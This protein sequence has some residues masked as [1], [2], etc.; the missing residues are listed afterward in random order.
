M[1]IVQQTKL[2]LCFLITLFSLNMGQA[3]SKV[4]T[5]GEVIS[6]VNKSINES[7]SIIQESNLPDLTTVEIV[8]ETTHK[9]LNDGSI[10]ILVF[11]FGKKRE[12]KATKKMTFVF[13][14]K[15]EIEQSD[16][17]D[18][19]SKALSDAI[20]QAA[21]ALKNINDDG[22]ILKPKSTT[23]ELGFYITDSKSGGLSWDVL[24]ISGSVTG[25]FDRSRT[26]FH[27]VKLVFGEE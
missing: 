23:I 25:K 27:S 13:E 3:Q 7:K 6:E 18:S 26:G 17:T 16:F 11:T 20:V 8:L 5:A 15:A 21:E 9:K 19:L 24:P 10:K 4:I 2:S 14:P 22:N 12:K 1:K